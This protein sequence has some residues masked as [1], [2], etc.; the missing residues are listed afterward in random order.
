MKPKTITQML[1]SL[2]RAQILQ[3][4]AYVQA[5]RARDEV[6]QRLIEA[7]LTSLT[8]SNGHAQR[9]VDDLLTVGEVARALKVGL[10]RAYE[11]CRTR[12]LR[13]VKVG[14]RQVRVRRSALDEYLA[15]SP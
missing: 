3:C 14:E 10:A 4:L 15:R 9:D 8:L 13:S 1:D 7:R 6:L 11:L 2:S 5:R 12:A